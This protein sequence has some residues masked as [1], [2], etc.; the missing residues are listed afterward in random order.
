LGEGR[1]LRLYR[2]AVEAAV[3]ELEGP[4]A[5]P[6]ARPHPELWSAVA[7]LADPEHLLGGEG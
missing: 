3:A 4:P 5:T 2:L 1:P 7:A 6:P